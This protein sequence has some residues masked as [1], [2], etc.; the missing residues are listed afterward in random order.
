MR[1][2]KF[3]RNSRSLVYFNMLTI[4]SPNT[5]VDNVDSLDKVHNQNSYKFYARY[6]FQRSVCFGT[7]C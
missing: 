3:V 2:F 5:E 4:I 1:F 6:F 7:F